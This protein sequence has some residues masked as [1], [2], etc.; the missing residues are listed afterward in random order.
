[1][2]NI[3]LLDAG[4]ASVPSQFRRPL[5]LFFQACV[6]FVILTQRRIA[7]QLTRS[8]RLPDARGGCQLGST[9]GSAET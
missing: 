8:K 9:S 4:H 1:M 5:P 7:E 2:P 3:S 6:S